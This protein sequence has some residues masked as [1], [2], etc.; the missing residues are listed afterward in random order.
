MKS[1][2]LDTGPLVAF[3]DRSDQFHRWAIEQFS[4]LPGGFLTCEA[5]ITEM[6][7]VIGSRVAKR[8]LPQFQRMLEAGV[9]R[10]PLVFAQE[11]GP[12]LELMDHYASVPMS[13]ADAC[14]VRMNEII[15]ASTVFTTDSDFRI[16][17]RSRRQ[18]IPLLIPD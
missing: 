3:L 10:T 18:L 11:Q 16:Y 4:R 6:F 17:R 2:V 15:P 9:I 1:I 13:F 14:L 7:Y 5:V 12:I 8:I